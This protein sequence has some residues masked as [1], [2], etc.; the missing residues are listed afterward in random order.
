MRRPAEGGQIGRHPSAG[1]AL[2]VALRRRVVVEMVLVV[3]LDVGDEDEEW[4]L[5]PSASVDVANRRICDRVHA[6]PRQLHLL[7]VAVVHHRVVGVGG[8]LQHVGRQP[9]AIAEASVGR[10]GPHGLAIVEVPLADVGRVVAGLAEV[11]RQG[12]AV[13]GKGNGVAVTA[14]GGGVEPCLQAGA[15]RA[16]D[17]LAGE[18]AGHVGVRPGDAVEVWRQVEGV[19]VKA[20][21]VPPLLVGEEHDDVGTGGAGHQPIS[22]FSPRPGRA[23]APATS[24]AGCPAR[25]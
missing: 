15:C 14:R 5:L 23:C 16:A 7:V 24:T 20:R 8:E 18:G 22:T 1:I 11:V 12:A 25:R 13:V 6:V 2:A 17:R 10:Y 19:A 21:G 9:V 3:R 4:I